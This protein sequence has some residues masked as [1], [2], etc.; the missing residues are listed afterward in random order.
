MSVNI[1]ICIF[2]K[3]KSIIWMHSWVLLTLVA[4]QGIAF[5]QQFIVCLWQINKHTYELTCVNGAHNAPFLLP[6]PL[7]F[8]SL[9]FAYLFWLW[10]RTVIQEAPEGQIVWIPRI[11]SFDFLASSSPYTFLPLLRRGVHQH[12][13]KQ[14]NFALLPRRNICI[15]HTPRCPPPFLALT[16]CVA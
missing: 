10:L 4:F 16:W 15:T 14:I 8:C 2:R 3:L 9:S 7:F 13:G 11:K 12:F 1:Y 5:I 6:L